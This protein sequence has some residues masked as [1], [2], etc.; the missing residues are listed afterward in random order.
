MKTNYKLP[1]LEEKL[2]Y[3]VGRTSENIIF[4]HFLEEDVNK[5]FDKWLKEKLE[6]IEK[7]RTKD[8]EEIN[9][10]LRRAKSQGKKPGRPIGSKDKK[11]RKTDGYYQREE[12]KRLILKNPPPNNSTQ[13]Q[14]AL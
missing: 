10:G 4:N 2:R 8:Y 1:N 9:E 14:S 11:K 5:A 13:F 3:K 12:R 7:A 6:K